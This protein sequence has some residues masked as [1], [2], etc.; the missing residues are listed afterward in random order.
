MAAAAAAPP[1]PA[2][3]GAGERLAVALQALGDALSL[4]AQTS[5]PPEVQELV[6]SWDVRTQALVGAATGGADGGRLQAAEAAAAGELLQPLMSEA[7]VSAHPDLFDK[8]FDA[9]VA[10]A[11]CCSEE[12]GCLASCA[13]AYPAPPCA[14]L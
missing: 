14:A 6:G 12:V 9:N 10:V 5:L 8:V 2:A 4:E 11:G 13:Y 3:P 1:A 7:F